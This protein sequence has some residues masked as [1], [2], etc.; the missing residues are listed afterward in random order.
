M[1]LW[2]L[3]FPDPHL[4]ARTAGHLLELD[5]KTIHDGTQW[6]QRADCRGSS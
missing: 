3:P 4:T 2:R 1:R 6:Y 5:L